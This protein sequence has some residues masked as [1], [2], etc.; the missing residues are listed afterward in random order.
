MG[1][2]RTETDRLFEGIFYVADLGS[3]FPAEAILW[4]NIAE[5]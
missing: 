4:S 3:P 2:T 5:K 1:S